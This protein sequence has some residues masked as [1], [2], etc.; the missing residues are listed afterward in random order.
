MKFLV[1][2]FMCM[3]VLGLTGEHKGAGLLAL[4]MAG[5][6]LYG[7][8][9]MR[10]RDIEYSAEMQDTPVIETDTAETMHTCCCEAGRSGF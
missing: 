9:V 4:A 7:E 2:I 5:F 8:R 10:K 3:A 1:V 6:T